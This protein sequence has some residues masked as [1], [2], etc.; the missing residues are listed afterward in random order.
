MQLYSK[1][2][3]GRKSVLEQTC[4]SCSWD[5]SRGVGGEGE[6]AA[7]AAT[8][9]SH[10][11]LGDNTRTFCFALPAFLFYPKGWRLEEE[12]SGEKRKAELKSKNEV[13][14]TLVCSEWTKGSTLTSHWK[15][16]VEN[17]LS[18][19][20]YLSREDLQWLKKSDCRSLATSL[21]PRNPKD[22]QKTA[23]LTLCLQPVN[24]LLHEWMPSAQAAATLDLKDV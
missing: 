11:R 4:E 23:F 10:Y 14:G 18:P 13:N 15:E 8:V 9:C 17:L 19:I 24:A 7:A 3:R 21:S 1:R 20:S 5:E 6:Q 2:S 16:C 22:L 12:G